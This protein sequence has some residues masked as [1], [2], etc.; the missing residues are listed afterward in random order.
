MNRGV[1]VV[2]SLFSIKPN[3]SQEE[4]KMAIVAGWCVEWVCYF[5][6]FIKQNLLLNLSFQLQAF[7]LVADDIMDKSEMRR[8]QP[9]WYLRPKVF[10]PFLPFK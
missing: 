4:V 7:F 9:C 2:S 10:T 3:C 8:G 5:I 6:Y 1:S